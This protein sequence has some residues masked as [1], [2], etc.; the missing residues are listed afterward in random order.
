[1]TRSA[2]Q[3]KWKKNDILNCF[4]KV[5]PKKIQLTYMEL[6]TFLIDQLEPLRKEY[7]DWKINQINIYKRALKL[8]IIPKNH[9]FLIEEEIKK[10]EKN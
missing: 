4:K 6:M 7:A 10:L 1:M 3:K 5:N 9:I 8:N 2:T